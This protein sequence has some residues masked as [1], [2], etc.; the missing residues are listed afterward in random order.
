MEEEGLAVL[1]LALSR[2][3]PGPFQ[4]K[5]AIAACQFQTP[6][7]WPQIAALYAA[8]HSHEPTPV[9]RLNHAVAL[10]ET[11]DLAA[12]QTLLATLALELSGYQPFHAARAE[13]LARSGQILAALDAYARAIELAASPADAAFLERRRARLLS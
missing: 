7:D 1:D 11:G 13:L 9:V 4:I 5:A 10:A 2:A 12:A 3:A 8:L 6:P